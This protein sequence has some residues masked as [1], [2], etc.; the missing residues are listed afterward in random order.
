MS[1]EIRRFKFFIINLIIKKQLLMSTFTLTTDTSSL[2]SLDERVVSPKQSPLKFEIVQEISH[3][4][5]Y[6]YLAW[7]PTEQEY[8]AVKL[9]PF[10]QGKPSVAYE[11][12]SRFAGLD[13][14]NVISIRETI[15]ETECPL[16][17][18]DCNVS[19]IL[20]EAYSFNFDEA[21]EKHSC[22]FDEKM[23]RTFFKQLI[24]GVEYLHS[25]GIAHLDLKL[26]NLMIS[27]DYELK[28]IDFD[29]SYIKGDKSIRTRGTANY[30]APELREK[31]C[32]DPV[33]ADIYSLGIILFTLLNQHIPYL[34]D[35]PVDGYD[36]QG[37]LY[38]DLQGFWEAQEILGEEESGSDSFKSLFELMT[39]EA[40]EERITLERVKNSEWFQGETYSSEEVAERFIA[41]LSAKN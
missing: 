32:F 6:V 20:M 28:I 34:E 8:L 3:S 9:F 25:Q 12:E 2:N 33:A 17:N 31:R 30:R 16:P 39:K 41:A 4:N 14:P 24:S 21:L 37:L 7:V 1:S 22:L 15:T 29:H 23:C 19:Y 35:K 13:H 26:K 10:R 18:T 36:L 11:L 27:S 5:S 40:P 38:H